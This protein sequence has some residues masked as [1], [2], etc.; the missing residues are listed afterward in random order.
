VNGSTLSQAGILIDTNIV[1]AHFKSVPTV[2][3]KLQASAPIYLPAIVLG[4]LYFGARRSSNPAL[5]QQRIQQ[6]TAAVIVLATE[7]ATASVYG[8]IKAELTAA[9]ANDPRQRPLDRSLGQTI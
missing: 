2:T 3:P 9:G 7:S 4:E 6:F 8:Q 5:N 1:S